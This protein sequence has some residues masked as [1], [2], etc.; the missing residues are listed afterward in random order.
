MQ[1]KDKALFAAKELEKLYP[2]VECELIYNEPFELLIATRL[3]ARCTDKC[4]NTVTPL[5]F[6]RYPTI[7]A[8]ACADTCEVEKIIKP[9]GLY[10]V[11]AREIVAM[12]GQ[13]MNDFGGQIPQT[14]DELLS[15]SGVGRK[16]A[17]L[18][19]GELF[20]KPAYVCD[21]HVIKITNRLGLATGTD[22]LKVEKQ[23]RE[24]IPEAMS[25]DFCHRLV[26]YGRAVC[27]A[28]NPKCN[29]CVLKK[30]CFEQEKT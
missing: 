18:I 6:E 21:T 16:S 24:I 23:L 9:C 20:S 26:R 7:E 8:M 25:L 1:K 14:M 28:R 19:L 12:C 17:N 30:I 2:H 15:L 13:L 10:K 3:S 29:E 22:A 11:K 27:T 4:V 5:L